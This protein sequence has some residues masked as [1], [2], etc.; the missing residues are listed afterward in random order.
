MPKI[1]RQVGSTSQIVELVAQSTASSPPGLP[2]AG[3]TYST[4]GLTCYYKRNMASADAVVSLVTIG[5]LGTFT[6]GGFAAVDATNMTGVYEFHIPN[7]ALASGADTVTFCFQGAANLAPIFLEV[8]LTAVNNQSTGF[9]LV[10]ASA[11]V[12]QIAGAAVNTTSAQLGV[13]VVQYN[14]HTAQTDAN[15]YP[16]INVAD[17]AGTASAGT[18]GYV[19]IDWAHVNAPNSA[20]TL[21]STTISTSQAIASVSGAVGSVTGNVGGSVA[22]VTGNVG[23]N[24][25]SVTAA[26]N[27]SLTE[28]LSTPRSL[29][30]V[31]DGSI[32]LNDALWCAVAVA[33]GKEQVSGTTYTVQTP[34]TGTTI[35]T[36]TLD[37]GTAPTQR[38]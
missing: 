21:S 9:G 8:E 15:N 13:N 7:A 28:T 4:S 6:S 25:A 17:I 3:L 26:V 10:D 35:R 37:S 1:S 30:S 11:N 20:V 32:T 5:T 38:S 34:S 23:G 29:N 27:V 2:L 16:S 22:S 33:A 24:V 31:A 12:V 36:F 14:G 19:G 18:A